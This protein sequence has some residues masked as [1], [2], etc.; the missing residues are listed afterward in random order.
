MHEKVFSEGDIIPA[1]KFSASKKI[2]V[3]IPA[4][5]F[6]VVKLDAAKISCGEISI[7]LPSEILKTPYNTKL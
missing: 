4:T 6:Q 3:K 1:G 7:F 2:A 5:K